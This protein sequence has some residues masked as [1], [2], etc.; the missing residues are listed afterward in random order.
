MQ[1]VQGVQGLCIERWGGGGAEAV[2]RQRWCRG[3]REVQGACRP[4]SPM[5]RQPT[6]K[7]PARPMPLRA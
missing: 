7:A 1:G 3:C 6:V 5:K 2:R 4:V